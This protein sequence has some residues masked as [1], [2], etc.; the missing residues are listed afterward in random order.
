[1][2]TS[3]AFQ[4]GRHPQ[5][6]WSSDSGYQVTSDVFSCEKSR[7]W[8]TKGFVIHLPR[9]EHLAWC[10]CSQLSYPDTLSE[11]AHLNGW[12]TVSQ[13]SE[14]NILYTHNHTPTEAMELVDGTPWCGAVSSLPEQRPTGRRYTAPFS[15]SRY[16]RVF[17]EPQDRRLPI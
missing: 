13:I 16:V 2:G 4:L 5:Q 9:T 12:H 14:S 3:A 11:V 7:S 6:W 15:E 8:M 17:R 10:S 1:M